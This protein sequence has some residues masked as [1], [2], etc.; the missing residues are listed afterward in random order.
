MWLAISA[1]G[2]TLHEW[3][4]GAVQRPVVQT[5]NWKD[6]RKLSYSRQQFCL[7]PS[8]GKR[9]KL[10]MDFRKYASFSSLSMS[11]HEVHLYLSVFCFLLRSYFTF[12]LASLQHQFFLKYRAELSS[13]QSVA[14]GEFS[15]FLDDKIYLICDKRI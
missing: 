6:I 8:S 9:L 5:Y 13:L 4:A 2:I 15:Q 11:F 10:R 1:S 3:R 12:R 14:T 7:Q